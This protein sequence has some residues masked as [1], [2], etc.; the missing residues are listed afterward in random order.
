MVQYL[1]KLERDIV[2]FFGKMR[3]C[4]LKHQKL[5]SLLLMSFEISAPKH[6]IVLELKFAHIPIQ[7]NIIQWEMNSH[8][9]RKYI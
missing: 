2:I 5:Q 8:C 4:L 6:V 1:W 9:R 7:A 3:H